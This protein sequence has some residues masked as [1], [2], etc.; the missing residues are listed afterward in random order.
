MD[1]DASFPSNW[2][3]TRVVSRVR[4]TGLFYHKVAFGL[5]AFTGEDLNAAACWVIRNHLRIKKTWKITWL[6]AYD[7]IASDRTDVLRHT[8]RDLT[9]LYLN[10]FQGLLGLCLF[11]SPIL[12]VLKCYFNLFFLLSSYPVEANVMIFRI[13]Y[14]FA[15]V[16]KY[17]DRGLWRGWDDACEVDNAALIHVDVRTALNANM[18]NWKKKNKLKLFWVEPD[19]STAFPW[20]VWNL[21]LMNESQRCTALQNAH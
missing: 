8:N 11:S 9:L 12:L 13:N 20:C 18:R 19:I 14:R 15:V 2:W 7:N 16:P 21:A 17:V 6:T 1:L 3:F 10:T 4:W 5:T